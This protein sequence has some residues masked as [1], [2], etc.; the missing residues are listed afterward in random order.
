MGFDL[1]LTAIVPVREGSRRLKDKNISPFGDSN[2]LI[3]KLKQLKKVNL[4]KKIVV[5]SDSKKML[6]IASQING[7]STHFRSKEFSDEISQ[8]FGSVVKHIASN[9]SGDHILWAPVTAP[10]VT[11]KIFHDAILKYFEVIND[12]FDSLI[13][14][15]VIKRYIW[16]ETG[17]LN[18]ELG[19]KHVPSQDLPELYFVTDG[20]IIAKRLDMIRWSYFHGVNPYKYRL[21]KIASVDIDDELDLLQAKAWYELNLKKISKN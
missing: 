20:I 10:L 12:N 6:D 14:V 8:P 1:T 11:E 5:S 2:L 9:V 13:S 17:P 3:H 16:E 18:Y 7:V 21:D 19:L 15:E 4:I